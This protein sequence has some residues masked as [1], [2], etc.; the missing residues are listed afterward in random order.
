ME[1]LKKM[2][3]SVLFW[4]WATL[5][6]LVALLFNT[7]FQVRIT[8]RF[9]LGRNAE[10]TEQASSTDADADIAR[11]ASYV[12]PQDGVELPAK[13]GDFGKQLVDSGAID[14]A[15]FEALY[16]GRGG[17]SSE[18]QQLLYGADNG[19]LRIT[20][21]NA[22]FLLNTLWAFGLANK[23]SI[24]DEGEMQDPQYGGAGGF[25]STGGWT[26]AEGDAMDHYSMHGFLELTPEQQK[27]VDEVSRNIYRPCCGNSV[28]FPDCNHGMAM[29]GLLELMAASGTSEEDMYR[30]ALAVN[31]FW[32]PETY[33]TIA[34]YL[35]GYGKPWESVP[36]KD[37]LGYN[38]SSAA[39]YQQIVS[40]VAP[41]ERPQGGGG[42]GV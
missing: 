10:P 40:A 5:G 42:C 7:L 38:F 25:A 34:K 16:A 27:R 12:L 11:F 3:G 2:F 1:S 37:I 22:D 30:Y 23:N 21:R 14:K 31:S 35:D 8:P 17:M 29:L 33:L 28:H 24:L 19:N 18:E 4:R 15:A 20:A 36:P 9:L 41:V 32:F 13:W 26:L 39:G 6:I